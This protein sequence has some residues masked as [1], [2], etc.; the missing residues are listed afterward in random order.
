M[1]DD[2]ALSMPSEGSLKIASARTFANSKD[3]E[4]GS[5]RSAD[6]FLIVHPDA[7]IKCYDAQR[8]PDNE[9]AQ[10]NKDHFQPLCH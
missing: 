8:R 7:V 4:R 3:V 9:N 2:K 1:G 6:Y 5:G 10:D